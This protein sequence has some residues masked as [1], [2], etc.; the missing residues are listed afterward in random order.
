LRR[1]AEIAATIN[2]ATMT[3]LAAIKTHSQTGISYSFRP[4]RDTRKT[5]VYATSVVTS[6]SAPR[7]R[8]GTGNAQ[9]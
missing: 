1:L 3:T 6:G 7:T 2:T 8:Q 5:V 9:K 4:G